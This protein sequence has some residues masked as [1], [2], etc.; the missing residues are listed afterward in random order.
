VRP[1]DLS[2]YLILD[3]GLCGGLEGMVQ[4]TAVATEHGVSLVQL[5]APGWSRSQLSAAA[6][7][8]R[9][10]LAPRRVPLIVNDDVEVAFEVD[11]DG[12][13]V[14][15]RDL[16]PAIA[17]RRLGDGKVIGLSI[18]NMTE[19]GAVP[20]ELVDY[21]GV[22]PV[23]PTGTKLDAAPVI[24]PAEQRAIIAAKRLP[25]V[26]IGGI[27]LGRVAPL[28]AAGFDGVAVVSAICG[29]PDVAAATRG[30]RAELMA[31]RRSR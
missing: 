19:L 23:Y 8:L 24:P 21:L 4:T 2:L 29:Q 28:L 16:L 13:H 27:G 9:A 7:A 3:P 6:R 30:L 25:A 11:A 15:Q 5:R 26:A 31:A 10:E 17:R 22:G 14:G 12:V 1:F 18:S 20:W